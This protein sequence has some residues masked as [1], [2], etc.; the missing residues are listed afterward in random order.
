MSGI[1]EIEQFLEPLPE[2]V[3]ESEERQSLQKRMSQMIVDPEESTAAEEVAPPSAEESPKKIH[4]PNRQEGH[5]APPEAPWITDQELY[6]LDEAFIDLANKLVEEGVKF[7]VGR[8][9]GSENHGSFLLDRGFGVAL[10]VRRAKKLD[11][12]P[13][14]FDAIGDEAFRVKLLTF[15]ID[16]LAPSFRYKDLIWSIKITSFFDMHPPANAPK[17]WRPGADFEKGEVHFA[18]SLPRLKRVGSLATQK[19]PHTSTSDFRA[20]SPETTSRAQ[21]RMSMRRSESVEPQSPVTPGRR[22]RFPTPLDRRPLWRHA[23]S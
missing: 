22:Q 2:S 9:V 3:I 23:G 19:R 13:I 4:I 15:S 5:R 8:Y 6:A 12:D 17:W 21:S 18:S 7:E 1:Y 10:C 14:S 16:F 20:Q 11:F